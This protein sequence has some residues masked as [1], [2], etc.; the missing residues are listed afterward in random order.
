[1]A[2]FLVSQS[3]LYGLAAVKSGIEEDD[4]VAMQLGA[5]DVSELT[6]RQQAYID[7]IKAKLAQVYPYFWL[8]QASHKSDCR[9]L[10]GLT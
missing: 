3:I 7:K 9:V 1:M 6:E 4:V 5:H 10:R 8:A 2:S